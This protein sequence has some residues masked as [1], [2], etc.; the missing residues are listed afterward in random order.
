MFLS[1]KKS[2]KCKGR[3]AFNGKPTRVWISNE[4]KSSPT[5]LNE[6]LFLTCAVDAHKGRDV[7]SMDVPN[8]YIQ[9]D[10]PQDDK[11][12]KVIMKVRGRLV[13]WLC[14]I[15][16]ESYQ[17]YVVYERGVKVLYLVILKAIYGMLQ[18]GLL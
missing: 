18:A 10:L 16:P 14:E 6:S 8:T 4:E 17:S 1:R 9:A 5:V 13:D 3:L 12:E 7:M 2:G 11:S 15:A